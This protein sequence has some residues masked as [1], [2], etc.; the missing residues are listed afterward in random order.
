MTNLDDERLACSRWTKEQV[1]CLRIMLS[2]GDNC[3]TIA[4]AL[5]RTRPAIF[6]KCREL[7][8]RFKSDGKFARKEGKQ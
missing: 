6:S 2:E 5:G 7:S 8:L 3:R 4:E 1:K